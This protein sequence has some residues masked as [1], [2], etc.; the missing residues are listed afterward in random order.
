M[1]HAAVD[2]GGAHPPLRLVYHAGALGDFITSL[3]AMDAWRGQDPTILLGKPAFA[4][5]ADPPFADVWD[6]G[7]ARWSSLF[8][9]SPRDA[10]LPAAIS[11]ALV[12]ASS[13]SPLP[14]GLRAQGVKDVTRLD[15]FP[16]RPQ[17]IVDFHLAQVGA[18]RAPGQAVPRIR[19]APEEREPSGSPRRVALAPGSGSPSKNWPGERFIA[20]AGRLRERRCPVTWVLGPAESAWPDSRDDGAWRDLGLA[21]LA[22]RLSR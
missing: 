4:V 7:D 17:P 1:G 15:P 18:L 11:H 2:H 13:S 6:A 16:E 9:E 12:F 21:V 20:L 10:G 22:A 14:G 5:L 19:L 8:G 3:P